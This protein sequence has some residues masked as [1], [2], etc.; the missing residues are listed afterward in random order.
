[1]S[2]IVAARNEA[3]NVPEIF[4]RLPK[5]GDRTELIFVEGH[6]KDHTFE[7]IQKSMAEHPEQ[8]CELLKQGGIGKGD[9]VRDGF[10][11]AT[12]DILMILDADLNQAFSRKGQSDWMRSLKIVARAQAMLWQSTPLKDRRNWLKLA[13]AETEALEEQTAAQRCEKVVFHEQR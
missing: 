9:A 4:S 11:R 8:P 13:E 2:V 7:A 12:G 5:M 10:Q 3:G 1:M 6:S